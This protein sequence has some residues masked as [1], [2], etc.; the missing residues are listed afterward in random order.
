MT[1]VRAGIDYDSAYRQSQAMLNY[2]PSR[3]ITEEYVE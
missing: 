3:P 2:D 1:M